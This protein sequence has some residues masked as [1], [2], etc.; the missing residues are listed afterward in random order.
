MSWFKYAMNHEPTM[1][2]SGIIGLSAIALPFFIVPVRR[3]MGLPTYQWDADPKTHPVSGAARALARRQRLL[4]EA[5]ALQRWALPGLG[6]L[7]QLRRA[8]PP[9]SCP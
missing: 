2:L 4:H 1:M 9:G 6:A 7:P 8:L 3:S 5:R